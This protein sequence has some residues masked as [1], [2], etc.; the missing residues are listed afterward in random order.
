MVGGEGESRVSRVV[1]SYLQTDER[2]RNA[3]D[4]RLL[5]FL[6]L[7]FHGGSPPRVLLRVHLFEAG[8]CLRPPTHPSPPR[9]CISPCKRDSLDRSSFPRY[10]G[11]SEK[12]GRKNNSWKETCWL[13]KFPCKCSFSLLLFERSLTILVRTFGRISNEETRS[14]RN[15]TVNQGTIL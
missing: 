1:V 12:K 2:R 13:D 3:L 9:V 4:P 14:I 5:S 10:V 11:C 8:A 15:W 7:R 6:S